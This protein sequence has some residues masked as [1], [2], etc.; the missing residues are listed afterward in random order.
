MSAV[1]CWLSHLIDDEDFSAGDVVADAIIGGIIGAVTGAVAANMV[2][3]TQLVSE[4][5][6]SGTGSEPATC[7][8]AASK[9]TRGST[10]R[11]ASTILSSA[12]GATVV[13][14]GAEAASFVSKY[15]TNTM[16]NAVNSCNVQITSSPVHLAS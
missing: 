8:T 4:S 6:E 16:G 9:V 11:A 12:Q 5:G 7:T 13:R 15:C 14:A 1:R 3:A 10:A 2:R